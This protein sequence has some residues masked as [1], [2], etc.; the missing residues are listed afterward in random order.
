MIMNIQDYFVNSTWQDKKYGY[1]IHEKL[2][3]TTNFSDIQ[4]YTI[5]L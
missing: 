1:Q 5:M 3:I 4:N 2:Q